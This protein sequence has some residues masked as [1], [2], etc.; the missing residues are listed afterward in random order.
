MQSVDFQYSTAPFYLM[1][2]FVSSNLNHGRIAKSASLN[3]FNLV[4]RLQMEFFGIQDALVLA[5][6]P[7]AIQGLGRSGGFEM[8]L[9]A[10]GNAD[11]S[12]LEDAANNLMV[13]AGTD[14]VLSRLN[15]TLRTNVPQLY[16]NLDRTKAMSLGDS[17]DINF[18]HTPNESWQYLYK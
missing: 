3:V 18:Q 12:T 10:R 5:F 2:A 8:Q 11:L 1:A 14:P 7:P 15:S 9:E 6:T 13:R 4:N 16:V 17:S